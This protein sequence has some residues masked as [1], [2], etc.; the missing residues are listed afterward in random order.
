MK[1]A[2]FWDV[3]PCRCG[4]NRRFGGTY[5]LHLQ[6]RGEIRKSTRKASFRDVK[7]RLVLEIKT[8]TVSHEGRGGGQVYMGNQWS[9]RGGKNLDRSRILYMILCW[10]RGGEARLKEEH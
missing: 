2:V 7:S 8:A 6:A 9:G 4:V 1:K 10:G 3:A 5:R